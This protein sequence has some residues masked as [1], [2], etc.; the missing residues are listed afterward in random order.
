MKQENCQITEDK[1]E[2]FFFW[3]TKM[4]EQILISLFITDPQILGGHC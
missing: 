2:L 3:K 4:S 1:H